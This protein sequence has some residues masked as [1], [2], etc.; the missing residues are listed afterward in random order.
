VAD[1]GIGISHE[2]QEHI[3]ERFYRPV[4]SLADEAG[5]LGVGLSIVKSLVEAHGGRVW[6]ESTLGEGS[7]FTVLLPVKRP[8]H[9]DQASP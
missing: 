4:S 6:M 9:A 5:G 2:K 7:V 1:S 3:W 8:R